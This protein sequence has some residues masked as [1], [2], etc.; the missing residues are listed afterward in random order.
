MWIHMPPLL[1][2][3][4]TY[5]ALCACSMTKFQKSWFAYARQFRKK[6]Q[7][8]LEI[9][10]SHWSPLLWWFVSVLQRS[11]FPQ[12]KSHVSRK[13]KSHQNWSL[14]THSR[15]TLRAI[16]IG[17]GHSLIYIWI[18]AIRSEQD[19]C[20]VM[21]VITVLVKVTVLLSPLPETNT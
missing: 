21:V 8:L 5:P 20:S 3:R 16:W 6:F 7:I 1:N 17:S 13:A 4:T 9:P 19:L 11:A 12:I 14:E 18:Q 10:N 15:C 2:W